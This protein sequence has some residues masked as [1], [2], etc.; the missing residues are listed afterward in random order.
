MAIIT[1]PVKQTGA[2][3]QLPE[4]GERPFGLQLLVFYKHQDLSSQETIQRL[5]NSLPQPHQSA[6]TSQ[7][8]TS[9]LPEP[10]FLGFLAKQT[11]LEPQEEERDDPM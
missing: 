10:S 9:I 11:P 4:D 6:F 7:N 8:I 3:S 2:I 1:P 5:E